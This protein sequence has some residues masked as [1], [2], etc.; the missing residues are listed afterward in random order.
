[1]AQSPEKL[2][3]AQHTKKFSEDSL[4]C[5]QDS[6]AKPYTEPDISSL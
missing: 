5:S 6:S 3:V 2:I 4:P 1:M